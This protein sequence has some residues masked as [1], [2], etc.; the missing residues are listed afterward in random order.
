MVMSSLIHRI[1]IGSALPAHFL[2]FATLSV[3]SDPGTVLSTLRLLSDAEV[4]V[5]ALQEVNVNEGI[6]A[7]LHNG[8]KD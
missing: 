7:Y 1:R 5:A 2:R 8:C 6:S 4:G 3:Q